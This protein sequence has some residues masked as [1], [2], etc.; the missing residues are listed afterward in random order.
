MD[1]NHFYDSGRYETIELLETNTF[2]GMFAS[3]HASLKELVSRTI[4][5]L[6]CNTI[7]TI[8]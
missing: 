2:W 1:I 8:L 5:S 6:L 7:F 4:G 3:L